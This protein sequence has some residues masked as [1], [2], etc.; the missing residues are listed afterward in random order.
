ML[1]FLAVFSALS[2]AAERGDEPPR[3]VAEG[4]EAFKNFGAQAAFD[5][6]LKGSA[7]EGDNAT[8]PALIE[9]ASQ[10]GQVY[11]RILGY[12]FIR[13]TPISPSIKRVYAAVLFEKG[14]LYLTFDC[15]RTAH[16]WIVSQLEANARIPSELSIAALESK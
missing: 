9:T 11:G 16:S 14:P 8:K 3:I 4:L 7:I 5:A 15:Y 6:W 12:E 13:V 10:A 2:E 1:C